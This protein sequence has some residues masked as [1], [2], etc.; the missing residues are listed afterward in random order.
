MATD[1]ARAGAHVCDV[2]AGLD[3]ASLKTTERYLALVVNDLRGA[4]AGRTYRN[5]D[6]LT[7]RAAP[8][9]RLTPGLRR[10]GCP[11]WSVPR[12]HLSRSGTAP[13]AR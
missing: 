2:Q 12:L 1:V 5:A 9:E 3:H 11:H 13:T 4:M 10:R 6:Q 7:A 8:G